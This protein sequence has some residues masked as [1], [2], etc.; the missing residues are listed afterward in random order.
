MDLDNVRI[1]TRIT[2]QKAAVTRAGFDKEQRKVKATADTA[3][4]ID[5]MVEKQRTKFNF[6]TIQLPS[7]VAATPA[8]PKREVL[9]IKPNSLTAMMLNPKMR[10]LRKTWMGS[11]YIKQI[12][13]WSKT[14]LRKSPSKKK[15]TRNHLQLQP[16]TEINSP[17]QTTVDPTD[18]PSFMPAVR[19][20]LVSDSNQIALESD[21]EPVASQEGKTK[22][23]R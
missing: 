22:Q 12:K 20:P 17:K 11:Y 9:P 8:E 15:F 18:G 23:T 4:P 14:L 3:L 7:L 10:S 21:I 13:T 2:Q 19:S 1:A 5:K 16:I 6:N